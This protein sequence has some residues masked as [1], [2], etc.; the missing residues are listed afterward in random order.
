MVRESPSPASSSRSARAWPFTS[1]ARKVEAS[2]TV[3]MVSSRASSP[4]RN[5]SSNSQSKVAATGIGSEMP[6]DSI[7]SWSKRP[8]RASLATASIRSSRSVQQMQPLVSST[9]FSSVRSR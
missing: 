5:P 7:T 8:S 9:S 2:T 3:T 6:V 1:S 4:R